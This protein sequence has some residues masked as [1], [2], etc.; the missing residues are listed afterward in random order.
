MS[1][2][3]VWRY[4]VFE[5]TV[6]NWRGEYG[7]EWRDAI[8]VL[9]IHGV[10]LMFSTNLYGLINIVNPSY[11]NKKTNNHNLFSKPSNIIIDIMVLRTKLFSNVNQEY[12]MHILQFWLKSI[13]QWKKPLLASIIY[14][15]F[16]IFMFK[17]I[18]N[19]NKWRKIS[20]KLQF[21][22]IWKWRNLDIDLRTSTI[23][24]VSTVDDAFHCRMSS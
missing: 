4:F 1:G 7:E 12:K 5:C 8:A 14:Y 15:S 20:T 3:V 18:L 13:H 2:R 17:V 22:W 6:G 23:F 9:I 11:S 16:Y 19:V 21:G 10:V 24:R